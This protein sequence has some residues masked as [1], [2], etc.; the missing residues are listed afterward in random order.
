MCDYEFGMKY[1]SEYV[2]IQ[3]TFL[4]SVPFGGKSS[5]VA[6]LLFETRDYLTFSFTTEAG[7]AAAPTAAA[8]FFTLCLVVISYL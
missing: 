8:V 6:S 3:L 7:A 2:K 1:G 4:W 5:F